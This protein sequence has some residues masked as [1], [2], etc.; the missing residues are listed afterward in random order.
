MIAKA[1]AEGDQVQRRQDYCQAEKQIWQD[2][3][4]I[5]LHSQKLPVVTTKQVSGVVTM[6]NEQFSTVYAAPAST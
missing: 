4:L 5:W 1:N 6:P 2:A 3:P